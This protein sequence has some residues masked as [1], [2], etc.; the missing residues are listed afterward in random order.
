MKSGVKAFQPPTQGVTQQS[1]RKVIENYSFGLG[2]EVGKG[3]S[4]KVYRG[5]ND[6]TGEEVGVKVIEM[7]LLKSDLHH[8]LLKSE[9][10]CLRMSKSDNVIKVHQVYQTQN[11]TYIFTEFCNGGDLG[12]RLAKDGKLSENVVMGFMMGIINGYKC[13]K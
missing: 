9:I 13:L 5:R 1:Q 11:N 6:T 8:Q 3:F 2:D 4:S 10:D 7:R 12:S